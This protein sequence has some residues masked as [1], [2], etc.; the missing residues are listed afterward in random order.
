MDDTSLTTKILDMGKRAGRRGLVKMGLLDDADN[1]IGNAQIVPPFANNSGFATVRLPDNPRG[2]RILFLDGLSRKAN[3]V[4]VGIAAQSILKP[5]SAGPQSLPAVITA[6]IEY[7]NGSQVSFIEVDVPVGRVSFSGGQLTNVE[8]GAMLVTLPA[9]TLR[10][11]GRNDSNYIVPDLSGLVG[12]ANL[13]NIVAPVDSGDADDALVK[14][15]VTY[16]TMRTSP[17]SG[18]PT[19]TYVIGRG[20]FGAVTA[21]NFVND[22]TRSYLVPPLAKRFKILRWNGTNAGDMPAFSGT[23]YDP[24]SNGLYNFSTLVDVVDQY[25]E[26][27]GVSHSVGIALNGIDRPNGYAAIVWEIGV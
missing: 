26:L 17:T 12:N 10:V 18:S 7:G 20:Q 25:K 16:H 9:G 4:T 19:R 8:D 5:L 23:V 2:E 24:D 6:T 11:W 1:N 14:A 15:F 21:I 3:V 27:P 13:N 22:P